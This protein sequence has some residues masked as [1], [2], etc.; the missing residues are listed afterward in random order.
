MNIL[1]TVCG[2]AGSKG[3]KNKNLKMF[4][5]KPL[6]CHTLEVIRQYRETAAS[7][8]LI[9]VCMNT[10]SEE[11]I[12]LGKEHTPDMMIFKRSVELAGE[13]RRA[14]CRERV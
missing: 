3:V 13:I 12:T 4:L 1:F 14:S 2:R 8:D 10:D 9:Y 5:G 6:V 7:D 11:L